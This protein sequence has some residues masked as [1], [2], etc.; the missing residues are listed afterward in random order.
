[1]Y[2]NQQWQQHNGVI[3]V[4]NLNWQMPITNNTNTRLRY[5]LPLTDGEKFDDMCICLDAVPNCDRQTEM[6]GRRKW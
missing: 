4:S 3:N 5:W 1:M 6:I 2:A